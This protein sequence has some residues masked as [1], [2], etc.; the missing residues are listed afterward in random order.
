MNREIAAGQPL[1]NKPKIVGV[2]SNPKVS[3]Q[4]SEAYQMNK[5]ELRFLANSRSKVNLSKVPVLSKRA[6]D[7]DE[8]QAQESRIITGY[9]AVFYDADEEGTEFDLFGDGSVLERIDRGAFTN[10]LD[11]PDDVRGLFNHSADYL[12]GRTA[13]ETVRLEV[14]DVGLKYS[15]DLPDTSLG[16]DMEVLIARKDITGSSFG[17]FVDGEKFERDGEVVIR[18]ITDVTLRDVAPVTFPAY[19]GT[20]VSERSKDSIRTYRGTPRLNMAKRREERRLAY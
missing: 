3:I 6:E 16:R 13:S 2:L 8:E 1:L 9:A 12:L 7:D 19:E 14:D 5:L 11:R 17:F 20:S 10:A 15:I 4:S 18:T